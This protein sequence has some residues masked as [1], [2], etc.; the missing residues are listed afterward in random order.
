MVSRGSRRRRA[1]Q[2]YKPVASELVF[3][4]DLEVWVLYKRVKNIA[5]RV[6]SPD[7]RI[8]ASVPVGA[9]LALVESFVRERHDWLLDQQRKVA[10]STMARAADASKEEVEQWRAVVAAFVPP[11]VEKWEHVLGVKAGK[12]AYR[13]MRSRWGSCQPSTGRICINI[14]LALY[15]PECLE[16]VVVHELCHL[17]VAG[18]GPDFYALMD[19]ALPTWRH[20]RALLK[21]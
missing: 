21:S 7:G 15:P 17:L 1:P 6:K 4:D 11:L 8:V 10:S 5:L 12:L 9:P 19:K 16:Y 20:A 18:H 13:N 14:R 2:S 3:I